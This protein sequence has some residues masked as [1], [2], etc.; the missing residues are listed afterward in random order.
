MEN[1]E[2]KAAFVRT[3]RANH[4]ETVEIQWCLED[5]AIYVERYT[6]PPKSVRD[7]R[8][9]DRAVMTVLL[10]EIEHKTRNAAGQV[11]DRLEENAA[12]QKYMLPPPHKNKLVL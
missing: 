11:V 6:L 7:A 1:R 9:A 3:V 5:G 10:A 2:Q 8:E 4:G 12:G